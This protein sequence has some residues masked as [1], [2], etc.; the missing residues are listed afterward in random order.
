MKPKFIHDS[1]CDTFLGTICVD[2]KW[3][4]VYYCPSEPT[5]IARFSN[6]GSDY[7][8]GISF[9][10]VGLAEAINGRKLHSGHLLAAYALA[11]ANGFALPNQTVGKLTTRDLINESYSYPLVE[12]FTAK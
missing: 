2:N 9:G 5:I 12:D 10:Q 8:S 1:T 11:L 6:E 3:A 7:A 4:D